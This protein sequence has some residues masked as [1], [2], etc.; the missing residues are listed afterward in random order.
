M[1]PTKFVKA[2][3]EKSTYQNPI[4]APA[5]RKSFI[6]EQAPSNARVIVSGLGFYDLWVNG[7]RITKGICAPYIS[8]PDDYVYFDAYDIHEKLHPGEN[9]L[10]VVLGHG[11]QNL[12]CPVWDFDRAKH[13]GPPRFAL[14]LLIDDEIIF[15]AGDFVT[16]NSPIL[17]N[18]YRSGVHY[19]ARLEEEG[20]ASPG[21]DASHWKPAI[22]AESP[23]GQFK[24]CE[25]DPIEIYN[26][27]KPVSVTPGE[28]FIG[29]MRGDVAALYSDKELPVGNPPLVGG[30]IYDFGVNTAG[31]YRLNLT[32]E[33]GQEISLQFAER[34][35]DG[36]VNPTNISFFY[37]DG[38]GQRDLYICKGDPKGEVYEP[39]FIYFGYR[40][41]YVTGITE[42]QATPDLLTCLEVSSA[43][44]TKA[45]FNASDPTIN[46]LWEI[47]QRSDISNFHYFPTDCPHREKN[48]WTGD[49]SM[50]AEHMIFTLDVEDSWREW[51]RNVCA[52]QNL[53]G[54]LPGIV[55]TAGWGFDWGNGPGWDSALFFLPYYAYL[56]S[57]DLSLAEIAAPSMVRYL[58]YID[59]QR[60]DEGIVAIGLGD[61]CPVGRKP[62]DYKMPLGLSDSS[63][64]F[65]MAERAAF[66][67][68][69]INYT[70]ERDYAKQLAS[71]MREDIRAKYFDPD[72]ARF[73]GDCQSSQAFGIYAGL[74][75]S[76]EVG[77]A[78]EYLLKL[79]E[80]QNHHM[81][82]GI[83]GGRVLFH[84][85]AQYGESDLALTM[86]RQPD[87]PS[88]G[89]LL[90]R[91]ATSLW[92]MF[93]PEGQLSGSENHHFWGDI[94]HW[95]LRYL[96][97]I[98]VNPQQ[99]DPEFIKISP[100]FNVDLTEVEGSYKTP[101]GEIHVQWKKTDDICELVV[102]TK[103]EAH[104]MM[105]IPEDFASTEGL[106][107]SL[108]KNTSTSI[109][110]ALK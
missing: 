73:A 18:D 6:L 62:D 54:A 106:D 60:D 17:F 23:R 81:D 78:F 87:Y 67:F 1:F 98:N 109:E 58:S 5:F 8:N 28:L 38:Y 53:E 63:F 89:N 44:K 27:R 88:Y 83:Y 96:C 103:G 19:D 110:L 33:P 84:V 31:I 40:Y 57:G 47:S 97:G 43:H 35:V 108:G 30:Y 95:F 100:H 9:V 14:Q 34:L 49:A 107:L 105:D 66:L 80:E 12:H 3:H 2:H 26:E 56:Y 48:G 68:D 55:P 25:A 76:S 64:V 75:D 16:H 51:L 4:P 11:F 101:Q 22:E 50:S 21:Y 102:T 69:R 13:N 42:D 71:E 32:A 39:A 74:C 99:D 41:I 90:E 20:W 37:P 52:A 36:K 86:I 29:D 94:S 10:A 72:T 7:E 46:K 77:R 61:W 104:G 65:L 45:T 82:V 92:E 24:L 79:I 93:L 70:K 85:L 15:D 91:G 59:K